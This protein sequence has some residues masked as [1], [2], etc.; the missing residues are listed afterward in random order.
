MCLCL[1]LEQL[2]EG[3]D[4]VRVEAPA[5]LAG[6]LRDR[7]ATPQRASVQAG[8]GDQSLVGRGDSHDAS[9]QRNIA[10]GGSVGLTLATPPRPM[11]PDEV[12]NRLWPLQ[13][14]QDGRRMV[15]VSIEEALSGGGREPGVRKD[16]LRD[17]RP[18][19]VVRLHSLMEE[20]RVGQR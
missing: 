20:D 6:E 11:G 15:R 17:P 5:G 8:R 13:R 12:E 7:L 14:A 18:A 9:G 2:G 10:A 19:E 3:R 16:G 1:L 4:H